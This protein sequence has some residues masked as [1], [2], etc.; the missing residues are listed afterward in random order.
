MKL[1]TERLKQLIREELENTNEAMENP[2]FQQP[3]A[4]VSVDF[5]GRFEYVHF[6]GMTDQKTGEF[7][8]KNND[9]SPK[10]A[11]KLASMKGKGMTIGDV[12]GLAEYLSRFVRNVNA[13]EIALAKV[14]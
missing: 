13:E 1:T 12:P 14:V 11:Q 7:D 8:L 5:R 2:S 10:A 9:L 3:E 4:R 6:V